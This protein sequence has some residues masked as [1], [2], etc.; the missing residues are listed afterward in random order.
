MDIND[1]CTKIL[2][3]LNLTCLQALAGGW[4]LTNDFC[5]SCTRQLMAALD[6][7]GGPL[8]WHPAYLGRAGQSSSR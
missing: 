6:G 4:N 7:I 1:D 8:R 5:P 2:P 3:G